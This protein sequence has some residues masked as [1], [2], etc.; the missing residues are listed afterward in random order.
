MAGVFSNQNKNNQR[1]SGSVFK[2]YKP[3]NKTEG[4]VSAEPNKPN[5]AELN[6][7]TDEEMQQYK[8]Y[9]P[10]RKFEPSSLLK[11]PLSKDDRA[12]IKEGLRRNFKPTE[13][14]KKQNIEEMKK[15]KSTAFALGLADGATL[16]LNS[17]LLQVAT[18]N[19]EGVKDL[20]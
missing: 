13:T 19:K 3:S 14:E 5:L 4:F 16:G 17:K 1:K 10:K 15:D 8:D 20:E 2:N 12:D 7:V 18:N 11:S 9:T 6:R